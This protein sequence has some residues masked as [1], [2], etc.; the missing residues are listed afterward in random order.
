[1]RTV[2]KYTTIFCIIVMMRLLAQADTLNITRLIS[3][4]KINSQICGVGTEGIA[5]QLVF[6]SDSNGVQTRS[7]YSPAVLD[8]TKHMRLTTFRFPGG[9]LGNFYHFYK[10]GYGVDTAETECAPGRLRNPFASAYAGNTVLSPRNYIYDFNEQ[11]QALKNDGNDVGVYYMLNINTHFYKHDISKYNSEIYNKLLLYSNN[12]PI[13]QTDGEVVMDS[14]Y[15]SAWVNFLNLVLSDTFFIRMKYEISHDSTFLYRFEENLN[16]I[17]YLRSQNIKILGAEFGNE[18]FAD[19]PLFDDDLSDFGYDCTNLPVGAYISST[20]A[21]LKTFFK[22]LIKMKIVASIYS[23][24]LR[25]MNIKMGLPYATSFSY[26]TYHA[27]MDTIL[28]VDPYTSVRRKFDL[29][30]AFFKS[31]TNL[32][33]AAIP[34]IY[35]QHIADCDYYTNETQKPALNK[36]LLRFYDRYA[37]FVMPKMIN[38]CVQNSGKKEIWITEWNYDGNSYSTNTMLAGYFIRSVLNSFEKIQTEDT[39]LHLAASYHSY[40][41][42][43]QG[44]VLIR[45]LRQPNTLLANRQMVCFP[46]E[47]YSSTIGKGVHKLNQ[48]HNIYLNL[49]GKVTDVYFSPEYKTLDLLYAHPDSATDYILLKNKTFM[50]DNIEYEV[51]RTKRFVLA[52]SS[53]TSSDLSVCPTVQRENNTYRVLYDSADVFV[54]SLPVPAISVGKFTLQLSPKITTHLFTAEQQVFK[55]YPNPAEDIL[56]IE[57]PETC[58]GAC[59]YKILGIDGKVFQEGIILNKNAT[60]SILSLPQGLF[61]LQFVKDNKVIGNQKFIKLK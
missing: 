47:M 46:F 20:T 39:S 34:H 55:I 61:V 40:A 7:Y 41:N 17:R 14:T 12:N 57:M 49:S 27:G 9:T 10:H 21:P 59:S 19:Y 31:H 35:F 13:L 24:S 11:L 37:D 36:L 48:S 56:H 50:I 32:A 54:D 15:T 60:V 53:L 51:K 28:F 43:Y 18:S 8:I 30:N 29:W 25:N 38:Q 33:D 1:M 6:E 26:L 22:G 3:T 58:V 4:P 52:A 16:A 42:G 2:F 45:T 5:D 44:F 23:D